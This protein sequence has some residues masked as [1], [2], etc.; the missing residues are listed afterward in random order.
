[1]ITT[2]CPD[3]DLAG[4]VDLRDK[5]IRELVVS[6]PVSEPFIPEFHQ[7]TGSHHSATINVNN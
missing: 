5:K 2:I 4:I 3:A 7:F 6:R 1:M